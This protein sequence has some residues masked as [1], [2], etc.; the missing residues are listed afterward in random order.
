MIYKF[1]G[2]MDFVSWQN[3]IDPYF[4]GQRR[5]CQGAFCG[6]DLQ[7]VLA[8]DDERLL[9]SSQSTS[10]HHPGLQHLTA[11]GGFAGQELDLIATCQLA[12]SPF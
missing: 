6:P 12:F 7:C 8:R 10:S 4:K 3:V 5:P 9:L 1:Y 2:A 11:S